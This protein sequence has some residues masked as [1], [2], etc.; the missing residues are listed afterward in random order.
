MNLRDRDFHTH[1]AEAL[2]KITSQD[3]GTDYDKWKAWYEKNK[4]K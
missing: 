1:V 4:D 2:T 3:F